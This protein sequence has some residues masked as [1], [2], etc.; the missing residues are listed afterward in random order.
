ML[1][2]LHMAIRIRV[3][4]KKKKK[5][6]LKSFDI[7]FRQVLI[8]PVKIFYLGLGLRIDCSEPQSSH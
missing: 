7:P 5:K 4:K 6:W 1:V 2:Y 8:F 3:L